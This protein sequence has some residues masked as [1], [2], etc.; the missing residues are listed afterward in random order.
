MNTKQNAHETAEFDREFISDTF[1]KPGEKARQQLERAKR[2]RGRQAHGAGAKAIS[3]T[4]EKPIPAQPRLG[5]RRTRPK[6]N[7][8]LESHLGEDRKDKK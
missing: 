7:G 4:V 5:G 6:S 1:G 2:Q 8:G 3:V